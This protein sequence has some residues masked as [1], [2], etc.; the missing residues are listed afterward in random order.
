MEGFRDDEP[1]LEIFR[2]WFELSDIGYNIKYNFKG[3]F[4]DQEELN[5]IQFNAIGI[6][7]FVLRKHIKELGIDDK[8]GVENNA[9]D[10]FSS[11]EESDEYDEKYYKYIIPYYNMASARVNQKQLRQINYADITIERKV[12]VYLI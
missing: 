11:E 1:A 6:T 8:S 10:L 12:M 4:V 2:N 7:F 5:F 9:S 3:G